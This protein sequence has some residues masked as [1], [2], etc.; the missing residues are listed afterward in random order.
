MVKKS[1]KIL[2]EISVG[3]L[4]DKISILE[5]K[6][7]KIKGKKNLIEIKKEYQ[8]LKKT[9]KLRFHLLQF[10]ILFMLLKIMVI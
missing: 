5:I 2:T 8:S 6:L 9:Q 1:K 7:N 3:E 10:I 4:I